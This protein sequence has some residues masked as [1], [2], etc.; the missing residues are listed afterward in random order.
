MGVKARLAGIFLR[1][2]SPAHCVM[3]ENMKTLKVHYDGSVLIPD[4]PVDLPLNRPLELSI[5]SLDNPSGA[6]AA[7][8]K[9]AALAQNHPAQDASQGDLAAQHDYYLYGTPK[10]L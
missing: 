1:L 3:V 4:E 2:P 6:P 10:R 7:L 9:L 8:D 5:V